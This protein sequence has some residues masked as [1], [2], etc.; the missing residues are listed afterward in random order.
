MYIAFFATY[1]SIFFYSDVV[2]G[3]AKGIAPTLLF[4]R[5]AAGRA[6]LDEAWEG[7]VISSLH[8]GSHL[9]DQTQ[10]DS[11][12]DVM[13]SVIADSD[14][15]AQLDEERVLAGDSQIAGSMEDLTQIVIYGRG[16][17]IQTE[18]GGDDNEIL[19]VDH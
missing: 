6:H 11:E 3:I 14:L 5:I 13:T 1:N 9:S 18:R 10:S 16:I 12:G 15:E 2:A 19:T 17:D 7:S 8:F 4:E